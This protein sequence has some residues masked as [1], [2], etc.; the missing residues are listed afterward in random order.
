M[1]DALDQELT[2]GDVVSFIPKGKRL[3]VLGIVTGF[4]KLK[5]EIAY[6]VYQVHYLTIENIKDFDMDKLGVCQVF[7]IVVS[8]IK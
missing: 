5:V 2:V 8:K 4:T 3:L 1:K 6:D 7:P